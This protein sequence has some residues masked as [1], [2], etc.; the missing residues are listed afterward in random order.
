M[1]VYCQA[2]VGSWTTAELNYFTLDT[3][4]AFSP[5]LSALLAVDLDPDLAD[6]LG[7]PTVDPH[8]LSAL[9]FQLRAGAGQP[10]PTQ[11]L[12][13]KFVPSDL[14]PSSGWKTHIEAA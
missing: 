7:L 4:G 13:L 11:G 3:L 6:S 14:S 12:P 5:T 2:R 10:V 1:K 9:E 8:Q